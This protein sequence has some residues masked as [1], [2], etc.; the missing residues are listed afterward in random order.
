[1]KTPVSKSKFKHVYAIHHHTSFGTGVQPM[2]GNTKKEAKERFKKR[3]PK[4][5]IIDCFE[6]DDHQFFSKPL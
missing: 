2:K 5:R 3:F 6:T 4:K 1:M